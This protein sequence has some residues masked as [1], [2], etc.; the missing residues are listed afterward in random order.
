MIRILRTTLTNSSGICPQIFV[1][2]VE[3]F[4]FVDECHRTQSGKLHRAM[5]TL[6]PDA[7]LIGFTGTPLLTS[8]K[9]RSIETFGPY[10]HTYKYDEAVQDEVVLDLRYEA[11]DIDQNITSEAR[12]DAFF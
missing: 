2:T 5:K 8:D 10:I 3:F 4:V 7:V 11:R 9:Q 1:L 6:L 12:I